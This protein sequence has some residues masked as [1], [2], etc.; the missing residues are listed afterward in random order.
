MD[1]LCLVDSGLFTF[2]YVNDERICDGS[3][4]HCQNGLAMARTK[5]RDRNH[6]SG[7]VRLVFT[8]G[9]DYKGAT[10]KKIAIYAGLFAILAG[11][12]APLATTAAQ[13]SMKANSDAVTITGRVSCSRFGGGSVTARKGM[14]VAQT[15]QFCANFMGGQYTIV[16]GKQIFLL[17]GD[18]NVL[19]KM[20]GQTV[21]VAGRVNTNEAERPSYALMGTVEAT[22]I[23]P[24]KN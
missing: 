10:M 12:L 2:V 7:S 15:I 22:S 20:S 24:A 13:S 5:R 11:T 3:F 19:A 16:S 21:T 1:C 8:K 6:R 23:S 18:K 9:N 4:D 14:S 17:T